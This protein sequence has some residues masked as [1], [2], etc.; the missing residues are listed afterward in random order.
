MKKQVRKVILF[1][2]VLLLAFGLTACSKKEAAKTQEVEVGFKPKLDTTTKCTITVVGH[3]SNFEA[4]EA[5]F[6]LFNQYYP[7]VEMNYTYLDNYNGIITTAVSSAEAPDIFFAY[8]WMAYQEKYASLYETAVDLA[9]PALGIDLSCIRSSLLYTDANGKVPTVPIYTT[10]YGM[11]VNENIFEKEGIKVPT[12]YSELISA[13]EALKKAGYANPIMAYNRGNFMLFSLY[14]PY[15]C[16]QVNGNET[17][18]KNLNSMAAGAGEYMRSSLELASDFMSR[19]FVDIES[20]NTLEN[21]YNAVIMRFFQGDIPMM[22]ASGNTVSGTEK[23]ESQSEAFTANPFR[24][25]F[26]PVPS[27]E[28]GG[29]FLNSISLG[30]AINGK[31][32]NLDMAKEFMRFLVNTEELNRMAKAKRMVTPCTE[33][34]LDDIYA[35][36]G[37]LDASHVINQSELG[38]DDAP[39]QQVR[40]AGWQ[41][42]NGNM[43]VDEA[44]AAFGTLQ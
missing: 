21:D 35:A 15:F 14:F 2:L 42:S 11:M 36:F 26:Q 40:K 7:N 16:A 9:D 18:L 17:A 38:L 39:D 3:Y 1:A 24:Y 12:T 25:S 30:F 41:V 32:A 33:M 4:L 44:V 31:S 13:C 43:T 34:A 28:Q 22:L 8:P 27:T 29:Y 23:R 10:T 5:E 19:G 6:N 37:Q 20:C